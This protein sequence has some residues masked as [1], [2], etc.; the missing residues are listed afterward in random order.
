MLCIKLLPWKSV[1]L[2]LNCKL[3]SQERIFK[4]HTLKKKS[5]KMCCCKLISNSSCEH[6]PVRQG[7]VFISCHG[8]LAGYKESCLHDPQYCLF[9]LQVHTWLIHSF[10]YTT[11][12]V[13][14]LKK[15]NNNLRAVSPCWIYIFCIFFMC[16]EPS[17]AWSHIQIPFNKTKICW[18]NKTLYPVKMWR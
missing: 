2:C 18:I 14:S 16:A 1:D 12:G 3:F 8:Y 10:S 9:K 17:K 6:N 4:K 7:Y 11:L 15:N 5:L 13:H